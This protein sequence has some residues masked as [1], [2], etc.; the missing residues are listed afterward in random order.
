MR[1]PSGPDVLDA[2]RCGSTVSVEYARSSQ[3]YSPMPRFSAVFAVAEVAEA[4][5]LI[6]RERVVDVGVD[7]DMLS[8]GV[9]Q[10]QRFRARAVPVS[11]SLM[12]G[13]SYESMPLT[14]RLNE[15]FCLISV[16]L[17]LSLK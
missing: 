15:A 12:F 7:V 16:P 1:R 4:Q 3:S 17:G 6:E 11:A 8:R 14:L 2:E 13:V 5:R 10:A 9:P